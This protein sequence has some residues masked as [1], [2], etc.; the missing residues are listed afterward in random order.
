V[1]LAG[2]PGPGRRDGHA[3]LHQRSATSLDR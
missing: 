1:F 3:S 2:N